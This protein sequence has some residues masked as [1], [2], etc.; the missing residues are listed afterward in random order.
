MNQLLKR[1]SNEL[2]A[3]KKKG[4]TLIELIIVI[5]II[6]IIAA[7]AIPKFGQV[8]EQANVASDQA[9]AKI[10]A[11]AVAQ[12]VSEGETPTPGEV[13]TGSNFVKYIDG[14]SVPKAKSKNATGFIVAYDST[15]TAATST[16][17]GTDATGTKVTLKGSGTTVYPVQ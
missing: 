17:A 9:N 3:K 4:F 7:I 16:T 13:T 6:A 15:G 1:K 14:G 5:A 10:I 2:S 12:A 11:T 8:K